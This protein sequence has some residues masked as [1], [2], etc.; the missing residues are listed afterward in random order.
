LTGYGSWTW[1]SHIE[2]SKHILIAVAR[3]SIHGKWFIDIYKLVH[4]DSEDE[5][6]LEEWKQEAAVIH[7]ID[8]D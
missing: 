4:L 7:N 6:V 8:L 1:L 2:G 5:Y 3:E